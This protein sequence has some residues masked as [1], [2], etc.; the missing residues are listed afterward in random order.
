MIDNPEEVSN[1]FNICFTNIGPNTEKT[2]P[3]S[4]KCLTSYLK[5][6]INTDFIIAHT[7]NEELMNIILTL[8]GNKSSGPSSIPV[9]L[10]KIALPMIIN[11]LCKLINHS[12]TT[13]IFPDAVKISKVIH[14]HKGGSMQDVNN[15]RPISLLSI[16]SKI[17]E[18][19]M[20]MRLYSF[21][22]QQKSICP[23]QFG[24]HPYNKPVKHHITIKINKKAIDEKEFIKYGCFNRFI[25]KLEISNFEYIKKDFT[26]YRNHV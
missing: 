8:D 5:N 13:G 11:P 9:K 10:L 3:K 20:H 23:S 4:G 7:S 25:F 26:S 22:K 19:L 14:I 17:I 24:F 16:F 15:Y 21:L 6:I 2:I 18:K 1:T 12:F